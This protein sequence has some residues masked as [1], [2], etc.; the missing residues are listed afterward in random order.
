MANYL[1]KIKVYGPDS[2]TN[3]YTRSTVIHVDTGDHAQAC[4]DAALDA[5]HEC[6]KNLAWADSGKETDP[7]AENDD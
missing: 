6:A 3:V 4:A 7:N 2:Q 5:A 1:L